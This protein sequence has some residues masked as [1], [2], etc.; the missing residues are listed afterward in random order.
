[1]KL[2]SITHKII[3]RFVSRDKD[4]LA[5]PR[6][7]RRLRQLVAAPV[8]GL[9]QRVKIV[10]G[11][12]VAVSAHDDVLDALDD[13]AQLQHGGLGR[14]RHRVHQV[15]AGDHVANVADWKRREY[16]ALEGQLGT[17]YTKFYNEK[18]FHGKKIQ[19]T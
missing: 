19:R 8:R 6:L 4:S 5:E 3:Q 1:M 15:A 2:I 11:L 12:A 7:D 9:V 17:G 16:W 13:A 18:L 14:R 10:H